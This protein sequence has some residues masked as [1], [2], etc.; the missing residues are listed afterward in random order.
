MEKVQIILLGKQKQPLYG[1]TVE[2]K[3]QEKVGWYK[4]VQN[5]NYKVGDGIFA[6]LEEQWAFC[7]PKNLEVYKVLEFEDGKF[8][9]D[10]L[11]NFN[12]ECMELTEIYND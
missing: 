2:D 3:E 9:L 8:S 7:C 4:I 11:T 12:E 1:K 6:T 10:D 5:G